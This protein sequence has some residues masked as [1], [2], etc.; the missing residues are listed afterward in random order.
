V[1]LGE[2][3]RSE[4]CGLVFGMG[5]VGDKMVVF[6]VSFLFCDKNWRCTS[7]AKMTKVCAQVTQA[8]RKRLESTV[9][10]GDRSEKEAEGK[11]LEKDK[12]HKEASVVRH[13]RPARNNRRH[14]AGCTPE[15]TSSKRRTRSVR[16]AT[17]GIATWRGPCIVVCELVKAS[18]Q[19]G[20]RHRY[21]G[22]TF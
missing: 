15:K 3:L 12:R 9:Q 10:R 20:S 6:F 11:K 14:P 16:K 2:R 21:R 22:C 4:N 18:E 13:G 7:A 1:E 19:G 5:C 8:G 17:I